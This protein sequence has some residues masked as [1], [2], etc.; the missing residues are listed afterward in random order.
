MQAIANIV[1]AISF[2]ILDIALSDI[3]RRGEWPFALT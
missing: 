2:R 1:I 3:N